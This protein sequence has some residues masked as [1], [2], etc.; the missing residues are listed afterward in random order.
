MRTRDGSCSFCVGQL[1]APFEMAFAAV[2]ESVNRAVAPPDLSPYRHA[3]HVAA[4]GTFH[5]EGGRLIST[6]TRCLVW[7]WVGHLRTLDLRRAA[8]YTRKGKKL[9]GDVR[10]RVSVVVF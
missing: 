2:H 7:L 5:R 3:G 1:D 9:S 8:V 6:R 4:A 10:Y